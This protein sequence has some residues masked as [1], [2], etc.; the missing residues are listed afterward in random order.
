[1]KDGQVL[2]K[3][4]NI[5]IAYDRINIM[6]NVCME[7]CS[8]DY[9]SIIGENG[10]GKSSLIKGI[11]GLGPMKNGE[12]IYGEGIE[13]KSLG[14]LPQQTPAQGDFP[15][16]VREV[17]LS[18][19]LTYD[20]FSPFYSQQSKKKAKSVMERLGIADMAKKTFGNL[21]GG[22]KQR[23]LLARALLATG[24][25]L[26]MDEPISGLDPIVTQQFYEIV[27]DL[28]KRDKMTIVMVSHDI[29]NAMKY[30]NKILHMKD[31]DYFFGTIGE[32]RNSNLA[33]GFIKGEERN[34]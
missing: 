10:T 30:S 32:Y 25:V 34:S 14:Y 21:S 9:I 19:S 31:N 11:L 13:K 18:G 7:I 20:K 12:I 1:M 29:A 8:G 6:E 23:V 16:S 3:C 27:E 5:T 2:L 28:N 4:E 17:V 15:A 22:Q 24:N 26:F 33:R